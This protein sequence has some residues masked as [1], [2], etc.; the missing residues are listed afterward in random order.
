MESFRSQDPTTQRFFTE[1]STTYWNKNSNKNSPHPLNE[2]KAVGTLDIVTRQEFERTKKQTDIL[3]IPVQQ[4]V[5]SVATCFSLTESHDISIGP[6][7]LPYINNIFETTTGCLSFYR[8][9]YIN[10]CFL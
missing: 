6:L 3:A 8:A 2:Y 5:E 4:I 1:I 9:T 7:D 10:L